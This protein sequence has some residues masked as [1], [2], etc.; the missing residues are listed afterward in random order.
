MRAFPVIYTEDVRRS[1]GF[2]E[3]LGF[4]Q[5]YQFPLEG[6]PGYVSLIRGDWTLG[7]TSVESPR[8]FLGLQ[9]IGDGPRF[10]LFVYVADVD[11]T[12]EQ[13]RGAGAP[14]LR[15]PEDMPWGERVAFVADPDG[16]PVSLANAAG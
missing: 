13:L 6:E 16:N 11:K 9:R 3:Q 8:Q 2:Y 1:V 10:E 14:V 12:V 4:E 7:I 5:Q 15:E